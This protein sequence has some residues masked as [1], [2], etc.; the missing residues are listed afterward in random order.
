MA[1]LKLIMMLLGCNPPGRNTE[2]HDVYFTI[3]SDIADT[4]PEIVKF[5][6]EANENGTIHIDAWREVTQVNNF[7]V[8]VYL[9][10]KEI[11]TAGISQQ[12]LFFINLGGYKENEFEEFHYKMLMAGNNKAEAILQSKLSAFFKHTSFNSAKSHIDDKYGIDVDDIFQIE[13]I[14]PI[15]IKENFIISVTPNVSNDVDKVN[16]GYFK[17]DN[18]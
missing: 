14:L 5:W 11:N 18:L 1:E 10:E 15:K 13:D 6:P 12:K 16:L 17:L 9:K 8:K 4:V 3:A 7:K 2:Q